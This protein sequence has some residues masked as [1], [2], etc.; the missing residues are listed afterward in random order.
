VVLNSEPHVTHVRFFSSRRRSR[1]LRCAQRSEQVNS[2]LR[3]S[4]CHW[5]RI[6]KPQPLQVRASVA[7]ARSLRVT[8]AAHTGT[9][10][11]RVRPPLPVQATRSLAMNA[12]ALASNGS[13]QRVQCPA[14]LK[15]ER[16]P[17]IH[18]EYQ[19]DSGY[20]EGW[21][22]KQGSSMLA[23][24]SSPSTRPPNAPH[25]SRTGGYAQNA[26]VVDTALVAI[27]DVAA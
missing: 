27:I 3:R 9:V 1:R 14:S 5:T 15:Y 26:S 25:I 7:S 13:W 12:R 16:C 18:C 22:G 11:V 24:K 6:A 23:T 4:S 10:S 19:K 17:F 8:H 2:Y 20:S 21:S